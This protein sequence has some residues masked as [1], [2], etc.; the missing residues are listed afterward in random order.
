MDAFASQSDS[1]PTTH[2]VADEQLVSLSEVIHRQ[3][4]LA[5]AWSF[6]QRHGAS[7]AGQETTADWWSYEARAKAGKEVTDRSFGHLIPFIAKEDLRVTMQL[8]AAPLL[9]IHHAVRRL[10]TQQWAR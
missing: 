8:R 6:R 7:D 10:M 4:G 2:R 5:G 9:V 3:H 1:P